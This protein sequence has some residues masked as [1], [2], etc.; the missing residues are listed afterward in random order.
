MTTKA[1]ATNAK[2]GKLEHIKI[3]NIC[4]SKDKI[5][6]W[7]GN[8]H[9]RKKN[10]QI[11]YLIRGSYHYAER[12]PTTGNPVQCWTDLNRHF[13][14][15]E[16]PIANMNVKRILTS[17]ITEKQI[18]TTM[19]YHTTPIRIATVKTHTQRENSVCYWQIWRD[20]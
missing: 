18:K 9:N 13:S 8:P 2:A 3:K 15:G 4:V 1:Q 6:K 5:N 7:K 12:T 17:L 14:K 10:F 20:K 19:R 11:L 16:I